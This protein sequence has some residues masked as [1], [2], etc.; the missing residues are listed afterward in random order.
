MTATGAPLFVRKSRDRSACSCA[1]GTG[2]PGGGRG[3]VGLAVST[4]AREATSWHAMPPPAHEPPAAPRR[5]ATSPGCAHAA[6][7]PAFSAQRRQAGCAGASPSCLR[8]PLQNLHLKRNHLANH[9]LDAYYLRWRR[10]QRNRRT[11]LCC[12][13]RLCA[14]RHG[15]VLR[16][17]GAA[18][19]AV[20]GTAVGGEAAL[21][22]RHVC[23]SRAERLSSPRRE[24]RG[25]GA[26]ARAAARQRRRRQ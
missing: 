13:A 6:H 8:P 17:R 14:V 18:C 7:R 3:V 15:A 16:R 4:N 23:P 21:P 25:G 24:Q 26:V 2:L 22:P 1:S 9:K 20:A 12:A 11:A 5:V 19:A 10:R